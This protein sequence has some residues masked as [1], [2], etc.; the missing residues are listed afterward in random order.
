MPAS[1]I[2]FLAHQGTES[3]TVIR[4]FLNETRS[5]GHAWRIGACARLPRQG[6]AYQQRATAAW[7]NDATYAVVD[8]ETRL[9]DLPY[10]QRGRGRSDYPYLRES[11]PQTNRHRFVEQ[12]LE[13]QIQAGRDVL[14]SPWLIHGVSGTNRELDATVDFA[15]RASNSAQRQGRTV[16]MGLEATEPILAAARTRNHFLNHAVEAPEMPVY[17]RLNVRGASGSKQYAEVAALQGLRRVVE[18]LNSNDRPVLLPQS[19]LAGWLMLPF[20]AR[21]FG[22]GCQFSMQ[23]NQ[24]L[25]SGGGGGGGGQ[26]P[27]HWYFLP[28][29]L[30]FVLAEELT[31][32]SSVPGFQP[33]SCPYCAA[34]PPTPGAAFDKQA[35]HKHFLWWC[36]SLANEVQQSANPTQ[37]VKRRLADASTFWAATRQAG[38]LLDSR[39]DPTHL[40]GWT[41]V[42]A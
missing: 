34:S 32:L 38:V 20:G 22:A 13:A 31:Q 23:R 8:P 11:D 21:A 30:G 40:A 27:L 7:D 19:G 16:L 37:Q 18:G 17:L 2:A 9:M 29:F 33:C 10:R 5:R 12:T 15:R 41:Q 26:A 28:Q 36:A 14:I 39:S 6:L 4:D 24:Q 25:R 42:V 3:F 35:A 1:G